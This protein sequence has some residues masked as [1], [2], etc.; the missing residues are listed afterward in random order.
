MLLLLLR[1][2]NGVGV[3]R[4]A[5]S[6]ED[7]NDHHQLPVISYIGHCIGYVFCAYGVF[8]LLVIN[9][10]IRFGI[11]FLKTFLCQLGKFSCVVR[12]PQFLN[13]FVFV[14]PFTALNIKIIYPEIT[15]IYIGFLLNYEGENI[16]VQIDHMLDGSGNGPVSLRGIFSYIVYIRNEKVI[17]FL[18]SGNGIFA[19]GD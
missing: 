19:E 12:N 4:T 1:K 17:N 11:G 9:F 2:G 5:H 6:R 13:E 8:Q 14:Q 10:Y 3:A 18:L 15:V 16:A 7:F